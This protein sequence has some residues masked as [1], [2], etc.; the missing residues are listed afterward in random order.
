MIAVWLLVAVLVVVAVLFWRATLR[1]AVRE[2][3]LNKEL[4]LYR[5]I[6]E[7]QGWATFAESDSDESGAENWRQVERQAREQLERFKP[8]RRRCE[9]EKVGWDR[10][11]QLL[12]AEG[13][14]EKPGK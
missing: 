6:V 4:S 13:L 2:F 9:E 7:A 14:Y 10:M 8:V 11:V 5:E 3:L 1:G 12:H